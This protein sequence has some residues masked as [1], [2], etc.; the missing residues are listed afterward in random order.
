MDL[1]NSCKIPQFQDAEGAGWG[2]G[3]G[4]SLLARET[5]EN[6]VDCRLLGGRPQHESFRE[7]RD[8][9]Q[10][11]RWALDLCCSM[12]LEGAIENKNREIAV[13]SKQLN[14]A[15]DQVS[16]LKSSVTNLTNE[17]VSIWAWWIFFY[18]S[19]SWNLLHWNVVLNQMFSHQPGSCREGN[20]AKRGTGSI[21]V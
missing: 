18:T 1:C 5:Q 4:G 6:F 12:V 9:G 7:T 16:A 13:L 2:G 3:G 20:S 11:C 21:S 10:E 14:T 19:M 15:R 17:K 8:G